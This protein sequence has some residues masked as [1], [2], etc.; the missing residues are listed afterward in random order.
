MEEKL[1]NKNLYKLELL[2]LK[3]LPIILAVFYFIGTVLS[4]NEDLEISF[5]SYISS[6]SLIPLLFMYLSSYVFQFCEYHRMFLH[7]IAFNM[8]INAIDWYIGIP[9]DD[10]LFIQ[11]YLI[12]TGICLFV[13]LYLYL[14]SRRDEKFNRPNTR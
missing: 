6:V 10:K 12:I 2:F 11:I 4:V 9:I 8:V 5:I 14:K 3:V 13:I 7:Y 1:R